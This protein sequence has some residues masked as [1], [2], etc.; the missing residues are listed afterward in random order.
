MTT[1]EYVK[2]LKAGWNL[3]NTLDSILH[4]RD[5]KKPHE[6]VWGNPKTTQEMIQ[7][8]R[9]AGF[10]IFRVP[11]TWY[12]EMGDAPGYIIN[13]EFLARV[14]E[15]VDYG[16]NIGMT[17][18]FN[19][20]HENWHF[21]SEENYPAAKERLIKVWTQLANYFADYSEK[22]IFEAMNEPRKEKTEVEWTGGDEEGRRMVMKM[23][24]VFVDTVRATGGKNSTR[25]LLVPN[26]A[27]S[28][29]EPA[30]VDFVMPVGEN[31][32]LSLHGYFP[33]DFALGDDHSKNKWSE[34]EQ[35][36]VD[37][38]FAR[39]EKYFLSKGIPVIMGETGARKKY[40]NVADRIE[41]AKY[42]TKKAREY[43]VP[44]CWWDNGYLEGPENSEVFG[45]LNRK[46]LEWGFPEV[47]KAFVG[48]GSQ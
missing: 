7:T 45:I 28:C 40:D 44:C 33:Y 21:P 38:L 46:T 12:Q 8:V 26:Y 31:I 3:G 36:E 1:F 13:E 27:A 16:I 32:I 30:M 19:L 34:S 14:K 6:T 10:D 15:V 2:N 4:R 23:N 41:W 11:V 5:G 35:T 37:D 48:G 25:M 20:H 24:Q 43:G 18:I 39:I 17:V 29:H 9:D 22:L 42:Y 47:V